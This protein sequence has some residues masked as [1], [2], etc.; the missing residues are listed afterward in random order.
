[1]ICSLGA[2]ARVRGAARRDWR[3][4]GPDGR[5]VGF[6]DED[7]ASGDSEDE[8]GGSGHREAAS[9]GSEGCA[10]QRGSSEEQQG[11]RNRAAGPS[12]APGGPQ[13]APAAGALQAGGNGFGD[14]DRDPLLALDRYRG[15]AWCQS[16][17]FDPAAGH[18]TSPV[19]ARIA[20]QMSSG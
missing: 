16:V 8:R 19:L 3:D 12:G 2:A 4:D 18:D 20:S 7:S 15:Q 10:P 1:M 6:F 13:R 5:R 9:A 17:G 11:S 14:E